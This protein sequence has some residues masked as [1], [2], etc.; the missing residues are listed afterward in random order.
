MGRAS[1]T[2]VFHSRTA[3]GGRLAAWKFASR[4]AE[5]RPATLP[6]V[7][8]RT[9][10]TL[11]EG[12]RIAS[13]MTETSVMWKAFIVAAGVA[14]F[15]MDVATTPRTLGIVQI[16][17]AVLA[18]GRL[19]PPETYELQLT[20]DEVTPAPGQAVGAERWIAFVLRGAVVGRE[21]AS[22]IPDADIDKIAEGPPPATG[23]SRIDVLKGGEYVRVWVN[24]DSV[25]Y[26]INLAVPTEDIRDR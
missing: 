6:N 10:Q 2:C 26:I 8:P 18:D 11:A 24:H 14:A 4:S 20:A 7:R 25:H 19:L 17:Q 15:I 23:T 9:N 3:A 13:V 5:F 1:A 12:T 22:V 16:P 21:L